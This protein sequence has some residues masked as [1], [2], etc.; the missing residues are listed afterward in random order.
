MEVLN[1]GVDAQIGDPS[2]PLLHRAVDPAEGSIAITKRRVNDTDLVREQASVAAQP[3]EI[4][5]NAQRPTAIVR[6]R[7]PVTQTGEHHGVI[8]R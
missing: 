4:A 3:F 1:P 8:R 6:G 7:E 2:R 5:H